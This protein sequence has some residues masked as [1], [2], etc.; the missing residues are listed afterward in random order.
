[1][2]A[3]FHKLYFNLEMVSGAIF[4]KYDNMSIC[5]AKTE[6]QV[7]RERT[8]TAELRIKTVLESHGLLWV[9]G[10]FCQIQ[11]NIC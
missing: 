4:L 2:K 10:I 3:K 11:C 7:R 5:F 9:N 8:L 6:L 1:M